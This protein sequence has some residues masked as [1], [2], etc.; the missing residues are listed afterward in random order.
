MAD[1]IIVGAGS[2]GCV[3]ANRLSANPNTSVLLLEAGGKDNA[4]EIHIP[5]A[6]NQTFRTAQDWNYFTEPQP[7]MS[8]RRLYWPRG[9]VLGG[10]SSINAM[11]YIRG[12]QKDYDGWAAHGNE[13]WA[14]EDVLPYFKKSEH[15]E[16]GGNEYHGVGGLLNVTNQ[17]CPNPMSEMFIEAGLEMGYPANDDFNGDSQE[18]V[19]LYQVTQKNGYR[20][21]AAAAF[22]TPI[23]N[24]PH[25]KVETHAH[26][27]RILF[28]GKRAV[29]IEYI[30]DGQ[31]RQASA[32]REILLCGG[33]INSP[34]LLMLSGIGAADELQKHDI[35]VLIDLPGV[36]KNLQD[37]L[38]T[39]ILFYAKK[40]I[41]LLNAEKPSSILQY[42]TR[43]NGPLTSIVAEAG[44]F[45]HTK[46]SLDVPDLQFHFA[47]VLFDN[48][49]LQPPT[50]HGYSVGVTLIAPESTGYLALRS[51]DPFAAPIIQPNYLTEEADMQTLEDGMIIAREVG[52]SKAFD[53]VR[54]EEHLPGADVVSREAIR[55]TVRNKAQTLY[56][57]VGTCKMG[58]D[59]MAVVGA[60]LRVHGVEGLRVVDASI[61][62]TIIR[63]NTNAPTIMIAEK[64]ADFILKP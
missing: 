24:R 39:G 40:K 56:H 11:I 22:L 60:D 19:G 44:G 62:P 37:H 9:K 18:G 50:E 55:Q 2:A 14:F 13:T 46:R 21:S 17:R 43:R 32:E 38:V 64:A 16:Q 12:N 8:G 6:F 54:R 30:Q 1:Y 26:V 41:S 4:R 42:L 31:T 15:R 49:G 33:A 53:E 48:H 47:P 20:H 3:L 57:P 58:Q 52:N 10:S 25:L 23:L 36:G 5:A 28:E 51:A 63:G 34:Q 61:M 7:C 27:T 29:G 59:S 45:I 35:S